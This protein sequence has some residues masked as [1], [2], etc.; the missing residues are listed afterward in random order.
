MDKTWQSVRFDVLPD[1]FLQPEGRRGFVWSHCGRGGSP[2][3]QKI[4]DILYIDL[5]VF[6]S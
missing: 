4:P 5:I 3:F 2:S 1:L 6:F